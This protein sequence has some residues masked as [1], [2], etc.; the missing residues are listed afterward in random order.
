MLNKLKADVGQTPVVVVKFDKKKR[1]CSD[2]INYTHESICAVIPCW[3]S[4]AGFESIKTGNPIVVEAID[5]VRTLTRGTAICYADGTQM[6]Y[7]MS[8]ITHQCE[9]IERT[10]NQGVTLN[11]FGE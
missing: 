8:F 4:S 1:R 9:F 6:V 3:K 5:D 2:P 10:C 7:G 11:C